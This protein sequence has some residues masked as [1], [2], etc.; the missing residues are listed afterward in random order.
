MQTTTKDSQRAG[1]LPISQS[2][3]RTPISAAAYGAVAVSSMRVLVEEQRGPQGGYFLCVDQK[4]LS[5][6]MAAKRRSE[7]LSGV[8][9]RMAEAEAMA[10]RRLSLASDRLTPQTPAIYRH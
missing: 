3:I 9:L 6:L 7:D 5:R 10:S 8:L 1:A 4:T 2:V